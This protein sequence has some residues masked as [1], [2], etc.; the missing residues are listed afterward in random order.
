MMKIHIL[1]LIIILYSGILRCQDVIIDSVYSDPVLD[2]EINYSPISQIYTINNWMYNMYVGDT[3][4]Y[5]TPN[6]YVRSYITFFLPE[7]PDGYSLETAIIRFYQHTS[8]GYNSYTEEYTDFPFWNV[9]DGDTIKCILSHIDYGD[10]L[11]YLDFDKGDID[12]PYTLNFR[13]GVVTESSDQGY[14]Y[15]DV[16]SCVQEDYDSLRNKTQYRISF[17]G[18]N[19]DYDSH[20]DLIEFTTGGWDTYQDAI[21]FLSFSNGTSI[22]K[23]TIFKS[24]INISNHPNPFNPITQISYFLSYPDNIKLEIFNIKG[25]KVKTLINEYQSTGEHSVIWNAEK[26]SSGIYFYRIVSGTKTQT[27]KCLLIK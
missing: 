23:N 18:I 14:R 8:Q 5:T 19:T 13:V 24:E 26:Q 25:E 15:Q 21:L 7:I 16:T 3:S 2:G 20:N 27:G 11:D 17:D 9:T 22:T 1:Q 10:E 6:S 4:Y 12:N